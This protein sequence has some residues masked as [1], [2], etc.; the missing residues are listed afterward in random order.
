MGRSV[1]PQQFERLYA[2]LKEDAAIEQILALRAMY[3]GPEEVVVMAKVNP[4][5]RMNIQQLAQAMDD[6]D[7]R[8]R[9]A[10]PF[11]ADVFIDVTA[12][13]TEEDSRA[14]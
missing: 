13:R 5:A 3:T 2:I 1:S 10:L 8:I 11:V 4:S 9:Q 12:S 7:G 6:L 14:G